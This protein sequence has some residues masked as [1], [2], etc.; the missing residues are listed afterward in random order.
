MADFVLREGRQEGIPQAHVDVNVTS[1][2]IATKSLSGR[3]NGDDPFGVPQ[4][5]MNMSSGTERARRSEQ[6][7]PPVHSSRYWAQ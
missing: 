3:V 7:P 6:G 5:R 2:V 1:Q 4:V